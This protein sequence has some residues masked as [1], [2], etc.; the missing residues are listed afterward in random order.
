MAEILTYAQFKNIK[1]SERK[2]LMLSPKVDANVN[3]ASMQLASN[4]GASNN[5]S[6]SVG[7][8]LLALNMFGMS[9]NE[10]IIFSTV[11]KYYNKGDENNVNNISVFQPQPKEFFGIWNIEEKYIV[12]EEP[13]GDIGSV[14]ESFIKF[15]E[16]GNIKNTY[17]KILKKAP[18]H[19]DGIFDK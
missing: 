3:M 16:K 14:S 1:D 8:G 6:A 9:T 12:K 7:L 4:L 11:A 13:H 10:K 15:M 17:D 19:E 2:S 18:I 5:A